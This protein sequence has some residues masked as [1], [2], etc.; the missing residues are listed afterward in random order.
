MYFGFTVRKKHT[1]SLIDGIINLKK[2]PFN[3][4]IDY[5]IFKIIYEIMRLTVNFKT[6][7]LFQ[8]PSVFI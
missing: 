5:A 4:V 8:L 6:E 7:R 3:C 1:A 2:C